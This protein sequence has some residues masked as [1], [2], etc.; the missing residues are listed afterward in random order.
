MKRTKFKVGIVGCGNIFLMHAQSLINTPSVELAAVCDIRA[1]R[2]KRAAKTVVQG[3]ARQQV[4]AG[5]FTRP[6][7]AAAR[8]CG[9]GNIGNDQPHD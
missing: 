2:A 3:I 4:A 6:F 7:D 1:F 5:G 9:A 8:R